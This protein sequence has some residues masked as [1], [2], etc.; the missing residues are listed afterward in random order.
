MKNKAFIN[1]YRFP[2]PLYITQPTLPDIEEYKKSL[3]TIW[4]SKWLTNNGSFHQSF[5]KKLCDYLEVT[6]LNL[7]CNGTTALLLSLKSL[8]LPEGEIITTPFT[9]PATP[10]AIT[11]NNLTPVFCDIKPGTFALD[12]SKI[13]EL[14]TPKTKGILPVHLFGYP[15]D[16]EEIEKIAQ[17]HKI[18]VIY[19]AAHAF[20]VRYK[21]K[22]L[23]SWGDGSVL[24]FHATK[25]FQTIEGGAIIPNSPELK[26]KIDLLKNF[27]IVDETT[28]EMVGINGKMN[29]FQAAFGLLQLKTHRDEI[30]ARKTLTNLYRKNLKGISGIVFPEDMEEVDH[31]YSSFPII[32]HASEYG[33]SRNNLYETLKEFNVFTRKYF[34]PL[35]STYPH[36]SHLVKNTKF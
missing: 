20:G 13:E 1:K 33:M 10:H 17:K 22:P 18:K 28:V 12:P 27:G 6:S 3:E 34:S 35:C 15:C 24:S 11:W 2:E 16:V 8:D 26:K 31:N 9:F 30:N 23:V 21:N 4:G 7:L 19:D 25:S 36:Y 29:E 32:V 14:I 5:E